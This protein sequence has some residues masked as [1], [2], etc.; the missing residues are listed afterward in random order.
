MKPFRLFPLLLIPALFVTAP[1]A[2]A[3]TKRPRGVMAIAQLQPLPGNK[4]HGIV[5]MA[6]Q[7]R[8]VSIIG[9]LIGAKGDLG[10]YELRLSRNTCRQ[11]RAGEK[12]PVFVAT[13]P[14]NNVG[15]WDGDGTI[16]V[17]DGT[18]NERIPLRGVRSMVF[19]TGDGGDDVRACGRVNRITLTEVLISS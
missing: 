12:N 3:G 1:T 19:T 7:R 8:K 16:G 18:S 5:H 13:N 6:V 15:D 9:V 14:N 17:L 4:E 11:F 10:D 2:G